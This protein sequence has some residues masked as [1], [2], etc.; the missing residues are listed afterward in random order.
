MTMVCPGYDTTEG[1]A[2]SRF[3]PAL[4]A[5]LLRSVKNTFLLGA[6]AE[7]WRAWSAD[8]AAAARCPSFDDLAN[9]GTMAEFQRLAY[10]AEGF[11]SLE[12]HDRTNPMGTVLEI[13]TP[14]LVI[15][16]DDDPVCTSKTSTRTRFVSTG[17]RR[18]RA[19]THRHHCCFYEGTR[20]CRETAGA[21]RGAG[22][23]QAVAEE[24]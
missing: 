22:V 16:A 8:E 12:Y 6:N 15:N 13:Q 17:V 18:A 4:D 7:T 23:F 20:W 2:F 9:T 19:D 14:T 24:K 10:G 5:H 11:A 21:R 1:G 3:E